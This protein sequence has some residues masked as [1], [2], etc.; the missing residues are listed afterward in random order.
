MAFDSDG[1]VHADNGTLTVIDEPNQDRFIP[2]TGVRFELFTL[3][4][5]VVPQTIT[6]LNPE[7]IA[8]S[9]FNASNPTRFYI[10]GWRAN[11]AKINRIP[12]GKFT[13]ICVK[14]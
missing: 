12:E 9:N 1:I 14:K 3:N 11:R 13:S 10:H 5:P 8:A 7:T 4:N 6:P 2:E